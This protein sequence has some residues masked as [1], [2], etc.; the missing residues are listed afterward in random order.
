[1]YFSPMYH[2]SGEKKKMMDTYCSLIPIIYLVLSDKTFFYTVLLEGA[3]QG[4][5]LLSNERK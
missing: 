5:H 1:M 4:H 3:C 2:A